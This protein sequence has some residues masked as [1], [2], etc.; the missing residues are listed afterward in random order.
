MFNG[1]T[2]KENHKHGPVSL[3]DGGPT[4]HL[5]GDIWNQTTLYVSARLHFR[6]TPRATQKHLWPVKTPRLGKHTR[7]T[8]V[9]ANLCARDP[10]EVKG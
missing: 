4:I 8:V 2:S 7:I 3:L 5:A 10:L 6:L 1:K 9:G